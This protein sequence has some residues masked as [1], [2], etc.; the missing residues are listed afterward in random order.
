MMTSRATGTNVA[1]RFNCI[2]SPFEVFVLDQHHR[3]AVGLLICGMN[4]GGYNE[5]E[6]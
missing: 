4:D 3:K 6:A 1:L 5:S 2:N